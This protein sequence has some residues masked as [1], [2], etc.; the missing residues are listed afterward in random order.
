MNTVLIFWFFFIKEKDQRE[1]RLH[2][3]RMGQKLKDLWEWG[4]IS[5]LQISYESLIQLPTT[6][7]VGLLIPFLQKRNDLDHIMGSDSTNIQSVHGDII[8][9]LM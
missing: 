1:D 9:L 6:F 4:V 7:T 5:Q 8:L 2:V 3:H